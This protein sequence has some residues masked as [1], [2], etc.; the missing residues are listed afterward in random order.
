[1]AEEAPPNPNDRARSAAEVVGQQTVI[2]VGHDQ[3]A[4]LR[5]VEQDVAV[6]SEILQHLKEVTVRLTDTMEALK[7]SVERMVRIAIV[8]G[9]LTFA[10]TAHGGQI[11]S[12]LASLFK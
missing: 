9:L 10:G 6:H 5:E 11:L 8:G 12:W 2:Q 1:M 4:R 3:E 7:G